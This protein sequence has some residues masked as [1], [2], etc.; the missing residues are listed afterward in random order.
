[1][2]TRSVNWDLFGA[3]AATLCTIHC[4]VLPAFLAMWPL[5]NGSGQ[6]QSTAAC[7]ARFEDGEASPAATPE[8]AR[9]SNSCCCSPAVDDW[10][11]IG[12]FAV[13]AP[14]G[15]IAWGRGYS[16]HGKLTVGGLGLT[17]LALLALALLQGSR[18]LSGHG[19]TVLTMAASLCIVIAHRWN[20][21]ECRCAACQP[22]KAF[23]STQH[24]TV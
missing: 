14:L 23:R 19:E 1:M 24:D 12:L 9:C 10:T 18:W 17:G 5:V 8:R 15:L 4:L 7:S 2:S 3:G 6:H 21:R 13:A 11:H 22:R 20:C 16:K